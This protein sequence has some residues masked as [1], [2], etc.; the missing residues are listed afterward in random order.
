MLVRRPVAESVVVQVLLTEW[1]RH[2][3]VFP[4]FIQAIT[5][6]CGVRLLKRRGLSL[7]KMGH[8]E[9]DIEL[10]IALVDAGSILWDKT[11]NIYKDRME[12]KKAWREVYVCLQ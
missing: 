5:F 10:L 4:G 9:F 1:F 11:V 7:V 8:Y 12:T 3:P 2:T 6:H